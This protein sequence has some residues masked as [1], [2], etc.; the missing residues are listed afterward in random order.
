MENTCQKDKEN[1]KCANCE[2]NHSV[3][4]RDCKK[5]KDANNQQTKQNQEVPVNQK[6]INIIIIFLISQ[7]FIVHSLI[8]I[9]IILSY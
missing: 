8:M 6:I 7:D 5:Y 4:Y 1:S 2:Q 3:F 9:K